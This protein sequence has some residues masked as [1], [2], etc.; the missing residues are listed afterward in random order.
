MSH[1]VRETP[2]CVIDVDT[3]Q[4]RIF[5][6]QRWR[7]TWLVQPPMAVWTRQEKR[8]FHHRADRHIWAAWSNRVRMNVRGTSSFA[9]RHVRAGVSMNLD[10][11]WVLRNEHWNV[12]VWKIPAGTLRI[13]SVG[14]TARTVTLDSND[15]QPRTFCDTATPRVCTTQIPV[16]HEFG[17][18]VGNTAVLSRGDEYR[19]TSP[20]VGDNTSIM[21]HGAVLRNRHFTTILEELN[22]MIPNTTFSVRSV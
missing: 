11:R 22:Q 1:I 13:S 18:T 5:L 12:S 8:D 7:Y 19:S 4:G 10:V 14:W 17:H 21:H 3:T 16:A 6:Q 15:F 2:W 20:N 9:R